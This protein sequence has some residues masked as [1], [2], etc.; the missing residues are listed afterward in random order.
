VSAAV[1]TGFGCGAES[2]FVVARLG[3]NGNGNGNGARL[4]GNGDGNGNGWNR[5]RPDA[6]IP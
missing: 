2:A 6:L 1:V 3:G 5:R 4:D